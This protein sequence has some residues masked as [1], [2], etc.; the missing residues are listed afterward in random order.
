MRCTDSSPCSSRVARKL[1]DATGFVTLQCPYCGERFE[2]AVDL[3]AGPFSYV[4]DCQV[5][6]QPIELN[7][8]MDDRGAF[9]GVIASRAD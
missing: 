9:A 4:E 5:C 7:S 2:T 3:S 8:E 1:A 6:C